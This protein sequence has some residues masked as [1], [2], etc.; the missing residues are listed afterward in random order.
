MNNLKNLALWKTV[1][2][3]SLISILMLCLFHTWARFY[4][5]AQETQLSQLQEKLKY[6][7]LLTILQC[8]MGILA[9]FLPVWIKKFIPLPYYLELMYYL[10]LCSAIYLGE[11]CNFYNRISYWDVVLHATSSILLSYLGVIAIKHCMEIHA[12][13]LEPVWVAA[14]TICFAITIGVLWE[15]YEYSFDGLLN[16]NMQ[17]F[18]LIDGTLLQGHAALQDTMSDLMVDV[19]FSFGTCWVWY[20]KQKRLPDQ[21]NDTRQSS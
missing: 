20:W 12:L 7:Y 11:F 9:S 18:Q 16:L 2:F 5:L 6:D 15:I 19:I 17:K 1:I 4:A 13:Q 14:I 3:Y 21:R 10:F 8:I